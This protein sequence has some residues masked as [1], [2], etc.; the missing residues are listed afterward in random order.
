MFVGSQSGILSCLTWAAN[1]TS[2]REIAV[3]LRSDKSKQRIYRSTFFLR[4]MRRSLAR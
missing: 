2:N 4:W 3:L 1:M